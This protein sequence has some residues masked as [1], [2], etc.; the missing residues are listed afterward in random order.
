MSS[1]SASSLLCACCEKQFASDLPGSGK[2]TGCHIDVYCSK[3]CQLKR[4]KARHRTECTG[5]R[6]CADAKDTGAPKDTGTHEDDDAFDDKTFTQLSKEA[7]EGNAERFVDLYEAWRSH[8]RRDP[9][10][11]YEQA[12]I[13]RRNMA[14]AGARG[15][16]KFVKAIQNMYFTNGELS[17]L[18]PSGDGADVKSTDGLFDVV[19]G[20]TIGPYGG[21]GGGYGGYGGY[22][23]GYGG[24]GGYSGGYV[25]YDDGYDPY[26]D[27]YDYQMR[28]AI[29]VANFPLFYTL[30]D[31]WLGLPRRYPVSRWNRRYMLDRHL[32][33]AYGR[34]HREFANTAWNRY[35]HGSRYPGPRGG[36]GGSGG[37]PRGGGG[38]GP[39]GG[40]GG[41]RGGR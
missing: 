28:A 15:N 3:E 19:L 39:R 10:T 36:G 33:Y 27:D 29:S 22:G 14:V 40:G 41:G 23:G 26:Y 25:G 9:L 32:G 24:Y 2:C 13:L 11:P 18:K 38:G 34:G 1:A 4:W 5:A 8:P 16:N 37:G 31:R 12:E 20:Q 35:G 7:L 6:P 21:Y 17:N 30:Y